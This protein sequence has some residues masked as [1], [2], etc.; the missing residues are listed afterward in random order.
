MLDLKKTPESVAELRRALK[1]AKARNPDA[2][3]ILAMMAG[4]KESRLREIAKG[5]E[6]DN[7]EY[8]ILALH[9]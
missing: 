5:E 2:F 4:I 6:P 3:N 9:A 8:Q 1:A 7:A